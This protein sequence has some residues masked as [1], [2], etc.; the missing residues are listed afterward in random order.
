[1][2][3][4]PRRGSRLWIVLFLFLTIALQAQVPEKISYQGLLTD[5][6]NTPIPD[7]NYNIVFTLYDAA[8]NGNA[9]WQESQSL[10][11][12]GGLLNALLGDVIPLNA[13][14][15]QPYW[16]GIK[17]GNDPELTPRTELTTSPYAMT[18]LNVADSSISSSKIQ[19][20]SVVRS[21]NNKTDNIQLAGGSNITITE[22]GNTL[23]I[24][25]V[26][27]GTG[28]IT[29]VQATDGL[30]GGGASGDVTVGIADDGV[31]AAKIAD[32]TTVRSL[33]TLQENV[34]I[35]AEGGATIMTRNDSLIIN[36]GAGG[37]VG[38]QGIQNT[39][40]TLSIS[41]PNGPTVTINVADGGI[42][43]TQLSD[44]SVTQAKLATAAVS[45]DQL[46]DSSV[47]QDKLANFSVGT[48]QLID[49]SITLDKIDPNLSLPPRGAA[50][51]DLD[52]IFPNPTVA[53]LQG[54]AVATTTPV[55]G[56]V[57]KFNGSA[58]TPDTDNAGS[59]LW[60]QSGTN[61][62]YNNGD[63]GIGTSSPDGKA[64]IFH[65]SSLSDPQLLLHENGNDYA[66]L[67]MQNN[68]GTN[69]W[70][71]AAYVASNVQNDR[72]NFWNGST[73]DVM[74]ITG[75]GQVGIDVGISPKVGFHVGDGNRV[76][77][78]A[79]TLG[80]GTKLMFLPHKRAFRVGTLAN[81]AASV[82]WNPDSIGEYSF[83]SG[84]NTRAQG[85]GSTAMGRDTE[86]SNSYS[87]ASGFFTNS[88]GQYATAMG[89]NTDARGLAST[90]LG[91]GSDAEEN[92]SVSI[93]YFT[94]AN[95]IYS[96]AFGNN[97][98]AQSYNSLAI[99]RYNVGGGSPTSWFDTDPLFEI[100]NGVSNTNRSNAMT[101][102]KNGNVGIGT[103]APGA[104]LHVNGIV[105]IG[106]AEE[107]EDVGAFQLAVNSTF[108]PLDDNLRDLGTSAFRW[109]DVYATNGTIQTSDRR[110]KM[111]IQNA[112]LGLNA[113]LQL[114]PVTYQWREG[115]DRSEKLG[116]IA[117]EVLPVV[118][119]AVKTHDYELSE[120]ED[121]PT[122]SR[123]ELERM[124]MNY[125]TLVPVLIKAIQEQQAKIEELEARLKKVEGN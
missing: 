122:V 88:D 79:D 16:L 119:Q 57:L 46:T 78:G 90:A 66:R 21:L 116:L 18:T 12:N 9:I 110:M 37:G 120:D 115:Y 3:Y 32:N 47:T 68:N 45:T 118:P 124:G 5:T 94:E 22:A 61:V 80:A 40:N 1:M 69:Y 25:A 70:T 54:R 13:S 23:T 98:R 81:G 15:E 24:N 27:V 20:G 8:Q 51:G 34:V 65:N 11:I 74:T 41:D 35:A 108:R 30:T 53:G 109:D 31:T 48:D 107:F 49:S 123:V 117:Q 64:E 36:A 75:D 17:I 26:G 113:V 99:G 106:S 62:Y 33:N 121:N 91:Y 59:N 73:G 71:I 44:T 6:N 103:T 72:L 89:F 50:G 28:D 77:F 125:S 86:A 112:S 38:V 56:Q 52:G 111:N 7:G 84:L 96:T 100:G 19:D 76:L 55:T 101:V 14:F 2:L 97:T 63:V 104:P 93:G 83:A 85:Y 39:N 43:T 105:R 4:A 58:W 42:G 60:S 29:G 67:R 95:A 102:R 82:Y 10:D 114:R 92:Y 87:F